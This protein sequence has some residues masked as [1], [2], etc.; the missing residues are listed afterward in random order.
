MSRLEEENRALRAENAALREQVSSLEQ[1]IKHLLGQIA[2]LERK[3][4]SGGRGGQG[5]P[6]PSRPSSGKPRGGQPGHKGHTREKPT[7][8][9]DTREHYPHDCPHCG[10]ALEPREEVT[11]RFEFEAVERAMKVLRHI[12]HQGFCPRCKR[13]VKAQATPLL[14]DSDYGPRAHGTL[15]T[16]RAAMGCTVG[17][18]ET[19][20]RNVWQ[21]PLSGGQIVAMLDRVTLALVPTFWW[22]VQQV[23]ESAVIYEDATSWQVDGERAVLWVFTTVKI[24][25]FWI[26]PSGSG[27]VPYVVLGEEIDGAVVTDSAERFQRVKHGEDQRCLAHPLRTARDLL[28]AHPDRPEVVQMMGAL[29]AH[30]SWTIS[31]F[32]RR[33]QLAPRTWLQYRAR[34]RREL[35]FIARGNWT[36]PDC[37]TMAKRIERDVDLWVTFLWDESGEMEPTNNRAERALRPAVIDRRS[38]Q[39][40]RSLRGV[41]REMVL[42]SVEATCKQLGID[43]QTVV[44]ETLLGRPREGPRENLSKT[45]VDAVQTAKSKVASTAPAQA[46]AGV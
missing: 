30:L 43:F 38:M 9:D 7:L 26:D 35:L 12:L 15:A 22:L 28:A 31:L 33:D 6:P 13:R 39:Q 2:A 40:S 41:Y 14:P 4:A 23:S 29:K 18:M 46:S 37:V 25:V 34:A 21:R 32:T 1:T 5:T 19:F 27:W 36:D 17:D 3:V 44:T 42:R 24:T 8:I 11:E 20:T 16:L 45:L 10:E